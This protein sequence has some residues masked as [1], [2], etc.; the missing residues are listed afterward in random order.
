MVKRR[1]EIINQRSK[2]L[3]F[4][5]FSV[6]YVMNWLIVYFRCDERVLQDE[7][8]DCRCPVNISSCELSGVSELSAHS[9]KETFTSGRE[10]FVSAPS[11]AQLIGRHLHAVVGVS[12]EAVDPSASRPRADDSWRDVCSR[13]SSDFTTAE[14]D[15]TD[16]L[17]PRQNTRH[18]YSPADKTQNTL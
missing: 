10:T 7:T 6:D 12:V 11:D 9:W 13:R 15:V 17:L 4:I 3:R 18:K 14:D 2:L 16:V 8:S 5:N 1:T